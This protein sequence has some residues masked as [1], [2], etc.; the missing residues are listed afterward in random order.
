LHT[1]R[2]RFSLPGRDHKLK[3]SPFGVCL[4]RF[5]VEFRNW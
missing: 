4:V 3:E 1:L 2:R 5:R